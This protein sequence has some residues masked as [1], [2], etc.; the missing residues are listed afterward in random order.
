MT[1]IF[2]K[3]TGLPVLPRVCSSR[4]V[5]CAVLAFAV[6]L[7]AAEAPEGAERVGDL[8]RKECLVF[9]GTQAFSPGGIVR[10]LELQLEFYG[11]SDPAEPLADYLAWIE[12]IVWRGYQNSGFAK[13]A[14]TVQAD[15]SAQRIRVKVTEGPRF[16]CGT[17][18]VTGLDPA[19]T[20]QLTRRLQ[21]AA[22]LREA[23]NG[24]GLPFFAW[25]W[26][27]GDPVPADP[28]S[29]A[30]FERSVVAALAE[31]NRHQA[32][33]QVELA[34]DESRQQAD[35][36]VQVK[37][38]GVVGT[39][40]QIDVDGLGVNSR[41]SLLSFLGLRPGMPLAGN[42]TNDVARRL[43]DSG[44]FS[45]HFARLSPLA[46][47]GRFK[48][49]VGV[50][51]ITHAPPINQELTAEEKAL[52]KLREWVLNWENRSEDWVFD[53]E[54][55]QN[56]HRVS[57]EAVLGQE[58]LA[59][60]IRQPAATHPPAL[61]YGL[62]AAPQH[63]GFYSGSQHSK[64]AGVPKGGQ[65]KSVLSMRGARKDGDSGNAY[66]FGAFWDPKGDGAPWSLRLELAPAAFVAAAHPLEGMCRVEQGILSVRSEVDEDSTFE[67]TA[68][69]ESGRLV[70]W[71]ISS[72]TNDLRVVL[73]GETGAFARV[74][75]EV[76]AESAGFKNMLDPQHPWGSSLAMLGRDIRETL[77]KDFP[78]V[79][80]WLGG[81]MT[82]GLNAKEL[83]EGLT[84]LEALPWRELLAPLDSFSGAPSEPDSGEAFPF[85]LEGPLPS[86][87]A[88]NDWLRL[89]GGGLLRANDDLW[90]RG[91][92]PWAV[93]R[94][95]TFLA[96]G[97][98]RWATHDT[99]R[100][101]R[102]ENTGPLACLIAAQVFG[103]LD[104]QLRLPFS[105]PGVARTT[106]AGLQNDLRLL[107]QG[108]KAGPQF[109][110]ET[111][112]RAPAFKEQD[113]R[114]FRKRIGTNAPLS[115]LL[116]TVAALETNSTLPPDE[117]LRPVIER[118]WE[119][120]IR[121]QLLTEFANS[122]LTG[123][124]PS[125]PRAK[126]P[127]ATAAVGWLREA[128]EQG[129]ARAQMSLGYLYLHGLVVTADPQ[130]AARWV[131]KAEEQ[132]YPHA[133]CTLGQLYAALGNR[134]EAARCFQ[135][136]AQKDCPAA[137]I[138]LAR[139][140]LNADGATPKQQ[141]EGIAL[142]RKA[143]ERGSPEAQ[144]YLGDI[145][146]QQGKMEDALNSYREAA[147]QG[148]VVAQA[149]LGALL[150]DGVS[151]K[152][153]YVEAWMW[154]KQ[155]EARGDRLAATHARSVERRLTGEQLEDAR[156]RLRQIE[157]T[158]GSA[159]KQAP[160]GNR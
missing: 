73:R 72:R 11:R 114:V 90:P 103:R 85:V 33:A 21:E 50:L 147:L 136:C 159:R 99:A 75:H 51:E 141:G 134:D 14:V 23:S 2:P 4:W 122:W 86:L 52:L 6:H 145:Y 100:L 105:Q 64:L 124:M 60:L 70:A 5:V 97:E 137:E 58:G 31:L 93:L 78:E 153:D 10:Q 28:A 109:L 110:R 16:K 81:D 150:C 27:E 46:E 36:R 101:A 25:P 95:A 62:I 59:I 49:E 98:A 55:T 151:T 116:D 123:L 79:I 53:A 18:K 115:I 37:K 158:P 82:G 47:A 106:P 96:V 125:S 155:A 118:H 154:L 132:G 35:L 144:T 71:R 3:W 120:E 42:V 112:R 41:E 130:I 45:D 135:R 69:A 67:M 77:E 29:L 127:A 146:E 24:V 61:R 119:K 129:C 108:D 133:A 113:L 54:V 89:L 148:V 63:L 76:A 34:L 131:R 26:R 157:K 30:S 138:G 121:P 32:E 140:L 15:R 7:P 152:P 92:W 160:E 143:A 57:A 56:G 1:T 156:R 40:D 38:P 65:L 43:W 19:L 80:D 126:E 139:L 12:R 88:G 84:I 39:L 128:A 20:E 44:R 142:L 22:A 66:S 74:L 68:E 94:G 87:E 9:E 107:L 111:L 83:L 13:A 104:P 91:S 149:R 48:L 102:A 8:G 117:V 17:V